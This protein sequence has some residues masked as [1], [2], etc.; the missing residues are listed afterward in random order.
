MNKNILT[1]ISTTIIPA[2]AASCASSN[3][4]VVPGHPFSR[5]FAPIHELTSKFSEHADWFWYE[6]IEFSNGEL[7]AGSHFNLT[8][9]CKDR[10]QEYYSFK[11]AT[12]GELEVISAPKAKYLESFE[13]TTFPKEM[14]AAFSD[15][16]NASD[17]DAIRNLRKLEPDAWPPFGLAD[18]LA[19]DDGW[20]IAYDIGEFGGALLWLPKTGDSYVIDEKNTHDLLKINETEVLAAQGL[21]HLSVRSGR[22][23]LVT[24]ETRTKLHRSAEGLMIGKPEERWLAYKKEYNA[25]SSV[26]KIAGDQNF[27]VGLTSYGLFIIGP[28][29]AIRSHSPYAEKSTHAVQRAQ[30]VYIDSSGVVYVAGVDMLGV[31]PNIP[32]SLEPVLYARRNCDFDFGVDPEPYR[33]SRDK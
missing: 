33:P 18:Y 11:G 9:K 27:L 5:D 7:T 15:R 19:F 12:N 4:G 10:P 26:N 21:D 3:P 29:D 30:D 17:E 25:G 28:D 22:I 14:L 16:N 8:Y 13:E 1:I 20:L 23:K 24:R 2:F 31:Y 32:Q 6:E